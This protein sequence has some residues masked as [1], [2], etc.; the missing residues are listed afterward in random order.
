MTTTLLNPGIRTT[1]SGK[2]ITALLYDHL[3]PFP[4]KSPVILSFYNYP[5]KYGHHVITIKDHLLEI[6]AVIFS[7]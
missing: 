5:R 2:N 7:C 3:F 6:P 4:N 1:F